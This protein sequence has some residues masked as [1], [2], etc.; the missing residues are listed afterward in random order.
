MKIF[1]KVLSKLGGFLST[2]IGAI[3]GRWFPSP[4]FGQSRV[5]V[6]GV[7]VTTETALRLTAVF[8][9]TKILSETVGSLPLILYR[10]KPNGDK[11]R[12]T[13]HWL[14]RL[15]RVA[16]ND[17]QT[18][19]EFFEMM[20]HHLSLAGNAY[21]EIIWNNQSQ[22]EQL[23]PLKPSRVMVQRL[24]NGAIRYTVTD[25]H[26]N[27]QRVIPE[28]SIFHLRSMSSDGL[29]GLSPIQSAM[30]SLGISIAT[31][32]FG[33]A[34]Y[35]NG[36]TV[37]NVLEHPDK[38]S[39][40]AHGRLLTSMNEK[41]GG[42]AQAHKTMILEEGLKLSHEG[43]TP[44]EAQFLK[45]RK[46][47]VNEI[48]R[49]YRVPPHMLGDLERASFNNMEQMA[50]EFVMYTMMPWFTA[51]E[52]KIR[53]DLLLDDQELFVEFLA[54]GVLRGDFKTR[55]NGYAKAIQ[56]GYMSRNE[57]RRKE[58]L[59]VEDDDLD[60]PLIPL[61]MRTTDEPP[62]QPTG[63]RGMDTDTGTSDANGAFIDDIAKRITASENA[64][65]KRHGGQRGDW[66]EK[67]KTRHA[68]HIAK[69]LAPVLEAREIE[70]EARDIVATAISDE[71]VADL[72]RS[73]DDCGEVLP[74]GRFRPNEIKAII[75][76]KTEAPCVTNK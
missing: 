15:I 3:N 55:T 38:L 51:W 75:N 70:T 11:E 57:V 53:R 47:G 64:A 5:S 48:A 50:L 74:C 59:P 31:E 16:P 33:A 23:K 7:S 8:A 24:T 27:K 58:N 2:R 6:A 71:I 67:Y 18:P 61:N 1:S 69:M 30:E 66:V 54:D 29:M 40:E 39:P 21:A 52:Q 43:V 20:Q 41:H 32:K 34:F 65:L 19:K 26:S 68:D 73:D 56:W 37:G 76:R 36:G 49:L 35:G 17:E 72:W 10:R 14:H 9:C 13:D 42:P 12:V 45:T 62:E 25:P 63:S 28:D 46:F 22:V 4:L 44:D 60:K